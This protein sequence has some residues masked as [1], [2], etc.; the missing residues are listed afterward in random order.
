MV[1]LHG[2]HYFHSQTSPWHL[3]SSLDWPHNLEKAPWN[4]LNSKPA[5]FGLMS[6]IIEPGTLLTPSLW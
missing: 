6:F 1:P 3:I 2:H 5:L 4:A